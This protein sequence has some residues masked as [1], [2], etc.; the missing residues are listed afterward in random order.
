MKPASAPPR[1]GTTN[2]APGWIAVGGGA[3]LAAVTVYLFVKSKPKPA[4]SGAAFVLPARGGALA[5]FTTRF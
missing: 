4:G 1:A 2:A 3:T 5:G